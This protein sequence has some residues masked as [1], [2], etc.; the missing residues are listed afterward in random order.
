VPANVTCVYIRQPEA[1]GL[2]HAVL[3]AQPVVGDEA[4]AV[5]LADDLID[6][7]RKCVLGQMIAVFN[8]HHCSIL[9]VEVVP[10]D[11][12]DKYGIVD[13]GK[14]DGCITRA[15]NIVEKPK[16]ADACSM[17]RLR[18]LLLVPGLYMAQASLSIG[19]RSHLLPADIAMTN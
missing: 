11:E 4:F 15:R 2:G 18:R 3:C 17:R 13:P 19:N 6:G 8:D 12:T 7:G 10:P 9:G 5:I 14:S 16:P 1:P